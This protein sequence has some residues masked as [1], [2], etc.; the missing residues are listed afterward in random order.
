MIKAYQK[1]FLK[2]SLFKILFMQK[3]VG[4]CLTSVCQILHMRYTSLL[5]GG[6]NSNKRG[7]VV[8]LVRTHIV[9]GSEVLTFLIVLCLEYL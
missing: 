7:V 8:V 3:T 4:F 5:A 1:R 2:N 6:Y 9:F